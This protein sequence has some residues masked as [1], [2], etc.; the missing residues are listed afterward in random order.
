MSGSKYYF[1]T[2]SLETTIQVQIHNSRCQEQ[3]FLDPVK[4]NT[5]LSPLDSLVGNGKVISLY[6]SCA[7]D[8]SDVMAVSVKGLLDNCTFQKTYAE[9]LEG[10]VSPALG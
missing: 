10:L 5:F 4:Q 8:G 2:S 3:F 1:L 6:F 7:M 9:G